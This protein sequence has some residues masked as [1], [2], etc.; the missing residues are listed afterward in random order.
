MKIQLPRQTMLLSIA[1]A[2]SG[3]L[4]LAACG[5]GGGDST[6]APSPT[7]S[8]TPPTLTPI[9]GPVP[10][11][12]EGT[13]V[14]A[15]NGTINGVSVG[16]V[17]GTVTGTLTQ[18]VGTSTVSNAVVNTPVNS[19][20]TV[21][22]NG[23]VTGSVTGTVTGVV[24][25]TASGTVTP[26]AVSAAPAAAIAKGFLQQFDSLRSSF[27]SSGTDTYSLNDGCYLGN[28]YS[29]AYLVNDWNTR[30]DNQARTAFD[31][32]STRANTTITVLSDTNATNAD[33]TARRTIRFRYAVNYTDG[34]RDNDAVETI[35]SGSS[36]GSTNADGSACTTSENKPEWRFYGNRRIVDF[37]FS[38]N[39]EELDRV[40]LSNG[41]D[42]NPATNYNKY[43]TLGMRDPAAVAKYFTIEGPDFRSTAGASSSATFIALSP[44]VLRDATVFPPTSVGGVVDWRDIDTFRFCRVSS[45]NGGFATASTADCRVSGASSSDFGSFGNAT[46]TLADTNFANFG[47]ALNQVY[48]IR[49]YNDNG[50]QT[51][52]GFAAST[53]IATFTR[54][55][56]VLPYSFAALTQAM[57]GDVNGT[58]I[59]ATGQVASE[60]IGVTIARAFRNKTAFTLAVG[61]TAPTANLPDGT[62]AGL[63]TWSTFSQGPAS[64]S[65]NPVNAF[66]RSR[67][68]QLF[69]PAPGST[70]FTVNHLAPNNNLGTPTYGEVNAVINNRNGNVFQRKTSWD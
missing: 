34:T 8:S 54:T 55:L 65:T 24:Q 36:A 63:G 18:V 38:A 68:L 40:N 44:R 47:F 59:T 33:G 67:Q 66:P 28:G 11:I 32:A 7:P 12:V 37:F 49:V 53:P 51:V 10:G 2:L 23:T 5:G 29:K 30:T 46:T 13:I 17:N 69:Y 50:W 21:T 57:A 48:T 20:S 35:I 42:K 58:S 4:I 16:L 25:G 6:P 43:I 62:R 64:T 26:P 19:T 39:N 61:I 41:L 56:D 3:S 14:G 1:V 22:V 31:I 52:N 70:S 9:A 60:G 27:K 45:T 15:A